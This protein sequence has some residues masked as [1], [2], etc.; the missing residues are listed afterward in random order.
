VKKA[1]KEA[2]SRSGSRRSGIRA[3]LRNSRQ[4]LRSPCR[5]QD[6]ESRKEA[7]HHPFMPPCRRALPRTP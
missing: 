5:T 6:K 3:V 2:A 1:Q 4:G 7:W